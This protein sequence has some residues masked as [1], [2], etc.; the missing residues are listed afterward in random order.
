MATAGRSPCRRA[1]CGHI[2]TEANALSAYPQLRNRHPV[3]S[4]AQ[5]SPLLSVE[6]PSVVLSNYMS[7]LSAPCPWKSGIQLEKFRPKSTCSRPAGRQSDGVTSVSSRD[8]EVR[9]DHL[10]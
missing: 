1:M 8:G 2:H 9:A 10:S 5:P 3:P 7:Y 4:P 6:G